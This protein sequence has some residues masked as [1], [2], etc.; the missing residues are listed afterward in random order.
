MRLRRWLRSCG[1][2]SA[3]EGERRIRR[4][5]SKSSETESKN[6]HEAARFLTLRTSARIRARGHY[7]KERDRQRWAPQAGPEGP[8]NFRDPAGLRSSDAGPF[9]KTLG[10]NEQRYDNAH[11][12]AVLPLSRIG[13]AVCG[14]RT[15]MDGVVAAATRNFDGAG[16]DGAWTL[17]AFDADLG[18]GLAAADT[19]RRV[20]SVDHGCHEAGVDFG[21]AARDCGCARNGVRLYPAA[22]ADDSR[23]AS[24]GERGT[25]GNG[26]GTGEGSDGRNSDSGAVR[27]RAGDRLPDDRETAVARDV[28]VYPARR[29]P[30]WV[31]LRCGG[32]DVAAG[33]V[34]ELD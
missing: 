6:R 22:R 7:D 1:S 31:A 14:L 5:G 24:R 18:A 13:W 12:R 19:E 3:H 26:A 11:D 20:P 28:I 9:G 15:R 25:A 8:V 10:L 4:G 29:N 30:D 2:F 33:R 21:D 27:A 16:A 17:Q 23:G 32:L 34:E